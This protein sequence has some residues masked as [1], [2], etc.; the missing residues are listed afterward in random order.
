MLT[1]KRGKWDRDYDGNTSK[2][3][4]R[5]DYRILLT[6]NVN[7]RA[8]VKQIPSQPLVTDFPMLLKGD[9]S[10]KIVALKKSLLLLC[11]RINCFL[12]YLDLIYSTTRGGGCRDSQSGSQ[13]L[14]QKKDTTQFYYQGRMLGSGWR[15]EDVDDESIECLPIKYILDTFLWVAYRIL[16]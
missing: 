4:E 14:R 8:V 11:E 9:P 6:D 15:M 13:L 2:W 10:N 12:V 7:W 3:R 1:W 16:L 5:G